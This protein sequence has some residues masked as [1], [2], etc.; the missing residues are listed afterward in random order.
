VKR[1]GRVTAGR[2]LQDRVLL[3]IKEQ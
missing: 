2:V 3:L 1:E